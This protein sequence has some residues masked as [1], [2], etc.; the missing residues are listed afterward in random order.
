MQK[1]A[2]EPIRRSR[3]GRR[4]PFPFNEMK[5]CNSPPF[6]GMPVAIPAT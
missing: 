3:H 2:Q 4:K 6:G 5:K 1:S